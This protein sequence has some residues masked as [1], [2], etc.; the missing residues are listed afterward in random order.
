MTEIAK[1]EDVIGIDRLIFKNYYTLWRRLDLG[2]SHV[3]QDIA[4]VSV[5][6]SLFD[7]YMSNCCVTSRS[8]LK[9]LPRV[10]F[11]TITP[12]SLQSLH[13]RLRRLAARL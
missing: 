1:V 5:W 8:L 10:L 12:V 13:E 6:M 2:M 11:A 3:L 4:G 9:A 7:V